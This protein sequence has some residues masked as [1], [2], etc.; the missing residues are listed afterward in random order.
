M[1]YP[2][3]PELYSVD[4]QFLVGSDLLVRPVTSAGATSSEI[5]FPLSHCWYDVDTMQRIPMSGDVNSVATKV[6][7]SDIDKIPVYQRGG[8]IIPRKL[9]LRRSSQLMVNDPY[10][11]Y[12]ALDEN[13]KADG[14]LYIDDETTFDYEKLNDYAIAKFSSDWGDSSLAIQNVVQNGSENGDIVNNKETRLIERIVVMGL[15]KEPAS[16]VSSTGA[17]IEFQYDS[18][19]KIL[20]IR[21]PGLS[22]LDNWTLD[23]QK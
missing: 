2:N 12:V 18:S 8:S 23:V 7:K 10:T 14:M 13:L 16:I 17:S 22:A 15:D 3:I 21:K 20:V 6:L 4:N 5:K 9:R 1:E 19:S 11:L